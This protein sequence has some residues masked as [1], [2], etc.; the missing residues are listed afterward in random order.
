MLENAIGEKR[1]L[2]RKMGYPKGP[3]LAA[4]GW[5]RRIIMEWKYNLE[6][7]I[8]NKDRSLPQIIGILGNL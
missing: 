3:L 7:E 5:W 8:D 6:W 4:V 1:K 2:G